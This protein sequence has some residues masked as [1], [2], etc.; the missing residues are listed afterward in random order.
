MRHDA[1]ADIIKEQNDIPVFP[2]GDVSNV[3][4]LPAALLYKGSL[5]HLKTSSLFLS[6][7]NSAKVFV[8]SSG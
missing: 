4:D 7:D 3:P 6:P 8:L 2:G 5:T 1:V